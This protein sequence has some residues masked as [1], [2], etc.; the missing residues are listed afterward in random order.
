VPR[1]SFHD[2]SPER[3]N[4]NTYAYDTK[5]GKRVRHHN[6]IDGRTTRHPGYALSQVVRKMIETLFGDGKRTCMFGE[7]AVEATRAR[8]PW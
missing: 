6:R 7:L 5:S 2:Q 3:E 4:Q 1:L 8:L